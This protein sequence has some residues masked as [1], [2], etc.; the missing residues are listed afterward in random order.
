MHIKQKVSGK[1]AI[2]KIWPQNN[3]EREANL[4]PE[5][6]KADRHDWA[7]AE[8]CATDTSV[9]LQ[10]KGIRYHTPYSARRLSCDT[11]R[12]LGGWKRWPLCWC[13]ASVCCSSTA[14]SLCLSCAARVTDAISSSWARSAFWLLCLERRKTTILLLVKTICPPFPSKITYGAN[15]L[16]NGDISNQ[17]GVVWLPTVCKISFSSN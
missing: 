4:H 6:L 8:L 11:N 13:W 5:H 10:N 12:H 3:R 17:R 15:I 1:T 9:R 14:S 16:L 2:N 7:D